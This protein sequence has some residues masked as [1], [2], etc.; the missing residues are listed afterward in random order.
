MVPLHM[1]YTK[2]Q[3]NYQK[4]YFF[5]S[6]KLLYFYFD[7]FFLMTF[8]MSTSVLCTRPVGAMSANLKKYY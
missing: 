8:F 1:Q 7:L 6:E 2:K 4:K 3:K 5:K